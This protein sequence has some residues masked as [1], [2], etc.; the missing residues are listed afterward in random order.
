VKKADDLVKAG[1]LVRDKGGRYLNGSC[2]RAHY[3]EDD[4][5]WDYY[6][7]SPERQKMPP[8]VFI[9]W[10]IVDGEEDG[11]FYSCA[12]VLKANGSVGNI[13]RHNLELVSEAR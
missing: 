13:L 1:D 8:A 4:W 5:G 6:E 11:E 3:D 10:H 2:Y 12:K 9:K 7:V